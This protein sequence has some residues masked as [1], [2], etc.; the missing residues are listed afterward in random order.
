MENTYL[1][2]WF[3][4]DNNDE[5]STYGIGQGSDSLAFQMVYWRCV[6]VFFASCMKVCPDYSR[7]FFTDGTLAD[8]PSEIRLHLDRLKVT[9]IQIPIEHRPPAGYW[10]AW[11]NQ[12]YVIDVCKWISEQKP[13]DDVY[14]VLDSDCI[15]VTP[16]DDMVAEIS[17]KGSISYKID[18]APDKEVNGLSAIQARDLYIELDK[19]P[20]LNMPLYLGGEIFAVTPDTAAMIYPKAHAAFTTSVERSALGLVKFCEE[21]HLLSYVYYCLN[22]EAGGANAYFRRIWTGLRYRNVF[23]KDD[24]LAIWHLPGEKKYGFSVLYNTLSSST[25]PIN[26]PGSGPEWR[27]YV[28]RL[29]NIP[30]YPMYKKVIFCLKWG[31]AKCAEVLR[32]GNRH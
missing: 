25:A 28:G 13:S 2:T 18:Y 16:I 23:D 11:N 3:V 27:E 12:F 10:K 4:A 32:L 14:I 22:L 15:I 7:V 30:R 29:V 19:E 24:A 17:K 31:I 6:V 1:C 5:S 20:V 8:I 21:A 26:M 9:V